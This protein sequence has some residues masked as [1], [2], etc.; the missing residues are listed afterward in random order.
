MIHHWKALDLEITDGE[1]HHDRTYT[2]E[3]T[4]S[5]TLNLKHVEIIKFQL[6]VHEIHHWKGLHLEITDSEHHHDWTRSVQTI[7][8]QTSN[9]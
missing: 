9:P 6:N 2:D 4:P 1:Y 7:Q 8:S 5:Q 3:T